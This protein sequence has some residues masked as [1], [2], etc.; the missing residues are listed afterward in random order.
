MQNKKPFVGGV[1]IFSGTAQYTHSFV[2]ENARYVVSSEQLGV[3]GELEGTEAEGTE[4]SV[5]ISY[6][7]S[8]QL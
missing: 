3:M 8:F 2:Q 6:Y 4:L 1:W 7:L 5:S